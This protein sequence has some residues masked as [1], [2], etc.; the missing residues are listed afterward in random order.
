MRIKRGIYE[1]DLGLVKKIDSD[2][3]H[4]VVYV[5]PRLKQ[6]N[7][8]KEKKKPTTHGVD[9]FEDNY[10]YNQ[11]DLDVN[12]LSREDNSKRTKKVEVQYDSKGRVIPK[13][14]D[15]EDFPDREI[16]PLSGPSYGRGI[17]SDSQNVNVELRMHNFT[18]LNGLLM[19]KFNM[20]ALEVEDVLP[21]YKEIEVF[22]ANQKNPQIRAIMKESAN[23]LNDTS[24]RLKK[25]L[26]RGDRICV[27]KGEYNGV[28][29]VVIDITKE[30]IKVDFSIFN[31]HFK[32]AIFFKANE[33]KKHFDVGENV[34]VIE[35]DR[36]GTIGKVTHVKDDTVH[37]F[38]N[39][40]SE[41]IIMFSSDVKRNNSLG[42]GG[43]RIFKRQAG[44]NKYD[45]VSFNNNL[46]VGMIIST[47]VG[48]SRILDING[49]LKKVPSIEI[50]NKITTD[51]VAK[52][53][54]NQ[55]IKPRYTVKVIQGKNTGKMVL[56]KQIY[57]NIIFLF[58]KNEVLNS[59]IFLENI[60]NCYLLNTYN[61]DNIQNQGKFNNE[62]V[63]G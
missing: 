36:K 49:C 35:G 4:V 30:S 8:R 31:K 48:F 58:D 11:N 32:N 61:Y 60:N 41:T 10:N 39:D 33:L 22:M 42:V 37:I 47:E 20:Q 24:K 50:Q 44:L 2:S 9:L 7:Q 59:G 34:E 18:F 23:K 38:L 14:F 15:R 26:Q 62:R 53:H 52:N 25:N 3:S 12:S 17:G 28:K 29:G 54:F 56:V 40:T 57:N 6:S 5:V 45:L 1:G 63:E 21:T 16:V 51:N 13:L 27:T 55:E 46:S 43:G 19:M